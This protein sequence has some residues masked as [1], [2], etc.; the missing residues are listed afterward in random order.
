MDKTYCLSLKE[1]LLAFM[2]AEIEVRES[3]GGCV[4]VLPTKT[5]DDRFVTVFVD[6]KADDYFL[7]HDAGKTAAELHGQGVHLTELRAETFSHMAERFGATFVDGMFQIGCHQDLL[8]TSVLAIG[9]CESMGTWHLLGHKP[10]LADEPIR[11]RVERG[12]MIWNAPHQYILERNVRVPG[13]KASHVFDFVSYPNNGGLREPIAIKVLTPSDDP[14]G[15][16]REYGFLVLDTEKT[17][18]EKWLRLAILAK[19]DRWSRPSKNLV[20]SLSTATLEVE[21]GDEPSIERR[22]PDALEQLAA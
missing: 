21:A 3:R 8:T 19:A 4:L 20:A 5:V 9:Q 10:D 15:K 17:Y 13:N 6:R 11:N 7:V 22:L 2:G 12:L 1:S 14:L 18:F 16:A